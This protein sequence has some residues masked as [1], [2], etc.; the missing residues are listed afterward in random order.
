MEK[1]VAERRTTPT[2]TKR[3][4]EINARIIKSATAVDEKQLVY[5]VVLE[6]LDIDLQQDWVSSD[7][8]EEAA[9]RFMAKSRVVG[10]YHKKQAPAEVV[11][12]YIAPADFM[13]GDEQVVKG[14]WVVA[15]H[16]INDSLWQAVKSGKYNAFSIGGFSQRVPALPTAV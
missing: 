8:L 6:P 15:V 4:I 10:D 5:G 12:S 3:S 2:Q 13:L 9:H 11:E 16:V 7:V 1:S 14:S